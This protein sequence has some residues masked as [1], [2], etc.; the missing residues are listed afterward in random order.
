MKKLDKFKINPQK[1][2]NNDELV[3]LRGGDYGGDHEIECYYG[4]TLVGTVYGPNCYDPSPGSLCFQE[5]GINCCDKF[6]CKP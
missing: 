3:N 1:I 6:I 4:D 5:F 2:I